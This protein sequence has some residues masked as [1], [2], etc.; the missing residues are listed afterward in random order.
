MR[1][2]LAK[3]DQVRRK[4]GGTDC[5][6][7]ASFYVP[8]LAPT[9]AKYGNISDLW[10]RLLHGVERSRTAVMARGIDAEP[11]LRKTL[12]EAY[13]YEMKPKPT[14]WIVQH[15]RFEF[16]SCSPDDVTTDG[17]LLIEIKSTSRFA[18][19][20]WGMPESDEIPPHIIAQVQWGMEILDL[21]RAHVFVGLG[22]DWKD[23]E[24]GEHQ[25]LYD[26]TI[27]YFVDRDRELAGMLLEHAERF[28][29]EFVETRK[30]PP[31][32]PIHNRRQFSRLIKEQSCQTE[33][34]EA[35]SQSSN[36]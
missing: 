31:L 16:A 25:F 22:A 11:R 1:A 26:E 30:P 23:A 27:S 36:P 3:A 2:R 32:T 19:K 21:P 24:T 5:G 35:P 12:I 7:P 13:G 10:M 9:L 17:S 18:R 34:T 15:P 4:I 33:A 28:M 20:N 29:K 14:P 6:A 8:S